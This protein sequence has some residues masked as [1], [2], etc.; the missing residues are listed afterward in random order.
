MM[1]T[2]LVWVMACCIAITAWHF[3]NDQI[4][5]VAQELYHT[6]LPC[7]SPVTYRIGRIDPSFHIA[8]STV[9]ADLSQAADMWNVGMKKQLFAYDQANGTVVVNFEYDQ[10]QATTDTLE[11][12]GSQMNANES[13]YTA[14][15]AEYQHAYTQY[16]QD[17]AAFLSSVSSYQ[18]RE[19]QYVDEVQAW[20]AKGGAPKSA[21]DSLQQQKQSLQQESVQLQSQQA[22]V[23]TEVA[24]V[25]TAAEDLNALIDE[26]NL[27]VAKYNTVGAESSGEFEQAVY[28][29]SPTAQTITVYEYENRLKLVRVLAHEL[30]HSLGL[31]H[32]ADPGAIMYKLNESSDEHLSPA[33]I[34]EVNA[35]C[36]SG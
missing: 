10:R 11:T 3:Y 13:T 36:R 15:K 23:N 2:I 4:R 6:A 16:Q 33:D 32:V 12:L 24:R 7:T 27:S 20:N 21:Y 17:K 14:M 34:Q 5:T 1:R 22:G 35:V 28:E 19:A 25:N 18:K 30:G 9:I 29:R 31:E 8:T 26:L